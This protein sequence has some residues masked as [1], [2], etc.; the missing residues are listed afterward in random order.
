LEMGS[1]QGQHFAFVKHKFGSYFETDIRV[2]SLTTSGMVSQRRH[3]FTLNA[4]DLSGIA[5]ESYDRVIAT[6]LL[7]HLSDP[8]KVLS[9]W[10]RVTRTGGYISIWVPC[11]PGLFLRFS[12][13]FTS[14]LIARVQG[15]NHLDYLYREHK[16][17]YLTCKYA[18]KDV[19]RSDQ[20]EAIYFPFKYLSWNFNYWKIF[21]IRK[22]GDQ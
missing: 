8:T 6:C 11:E 16:I 1:G 3:R 22:I 7:S 18:I 14:N 4:E 9:E 12:R 19:F 21:T 15:V 2:E 17:N 20:V 13:Y 5:D 10:R